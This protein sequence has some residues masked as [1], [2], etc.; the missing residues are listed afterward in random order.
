M[1]EVLYSPL[2]L[3]FE[4]ELNSEPYHLTIGWMK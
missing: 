2:T 4:T 1:G 3:A